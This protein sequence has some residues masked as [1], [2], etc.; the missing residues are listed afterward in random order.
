MQSPSAGLSLTGIVKNFS[1]TPA[2]ADVSLTV[3]EGRQMV[4]LGPSGCGK[5]T[6]LR[7]VAGLEREDAG[8]VSVCGQLLSRDGQGLPPEK[9]RIGMVFQDWALFPHMTVARN[10]AFGLDRRQIAAGA[11]AETLE[12]MH[13]SQLA[14]RRPHELSAGQAQRVALARALAPRPR[15][16]LFDEPF[17]SLDAELRVQVR[18]EVA[19]LMR[20]LRMT[21]VYVTHDQE[22]AFI[23]GDE[24]A[25]MRD[26]ALVQVG[27]PASIYADPATPWV[28]RFLGDA[29]LLPAVA[30]GPRAATGIGPMPLRQERRGDC[31]VLARPEHIVITPGA[32]A[33][34]RSVEF[35][36]HDTVYRVAARAAAAGGAADVL[37]RAAA[38]PEH[39]VGDSV[40]L[41]YVGPAAV[42]YA[43]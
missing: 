18:G 34:V 24:V 9:R 29:N 37:V 3:P 11:V 17:S 16:L 6:L 2:V 27:T 23:L 43:R 22:E 14:H 42:S 26:G 35:Y 13:M 8:T 12:L 36:G 33:T 40:S 32:D 20:E 10:V 4:L 30:D 7:V 28:A 21:A 15:L 39:T 38:A 5:T 19:D 1:D 41:R 31:E 25:V